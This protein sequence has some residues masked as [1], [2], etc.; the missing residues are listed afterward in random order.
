MGL[1]ASNA[2]LRQNSLLG[3]FRTFT[4]YFETSGLIIRV[5]SG[6]VCDLGFVNEGDDKFVLALHAATDSY[7]GYL[8][9][10]EGIR[11]KL[12]ASADNFD[13][14]TMF[15]LEISWDGKWTADLNKMA[16]H[17]MVKPLP[18]GL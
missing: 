16:K 13:P 11:L 1:M 2:R 7:P 12:S 8:R 3:D 15:D 4:E 14:R 9:A 5:H 18:T 6:T 10:N 17:L